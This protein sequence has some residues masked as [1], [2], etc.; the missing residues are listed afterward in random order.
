MSVT[1]LLS[2]PIPGTSAPA[3]LLAQLG[4]EA[5]ASTSVGYAFSVGQQDNS[6]GR[7]TMIGAV[8]R[9]CRESLVI[10]FDPFQLGLESH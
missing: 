9:L 4:F 8:L 10:G 7:E 6:V 1:A 2:F 5:L 3:R